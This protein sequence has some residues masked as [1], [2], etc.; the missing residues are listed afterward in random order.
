[1]RLMSRLVLAAVLA[2]TTL[3]PTAA[4]ERKL[5][6]E[7]ESLYNN[8]FIYSDP[9][10][11]SLTFGH[12]G[13]LYT[14]SIYNTKDELDLP[15]VYTRYM[16]AGLI[17]PKEIKSILEIGSGGGRTAWYLHRHLPDV[18]VTTVELDPVVA[19]FAQKYFGIKEEKN[20]NIVTRD[21][22]LFLREN[23][24]KRYDMIL[25]DAYRGPFVPFHL[26][27]KEF[28]EVVKSHLT[29]G[30]VVVQN[31][32]P[33]T[34]LFDSATKTIQAV[35]PNVE[36]YLGQGNVVTIAYDGPKRPLADIKAAAAERQK[37]LKLR[38][39]LTKLMEERRELSPE[40]GTISPDAKV[41]TD[42]FAPVEALKAIEKH[43]RKWPSK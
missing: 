14:E 16:T 32:E 34:M 22:R 13:R 25:I 21:G 28:Y 37:A 39:D 11:V 38:Y 17:Y 36:F 2:L 19:E 31:I 42:D 18:P 41:L 15:V 29:E 30:G 26:M 9:P 6:V 35:F 40:V 27:T 12:N 4:G 20:F 7:K 24:Q 8:I 10:Y 33:T 3:A 43:N 1:M 23:K 5:L